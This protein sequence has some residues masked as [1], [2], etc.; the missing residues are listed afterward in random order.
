MLLAD[1]ERQLSEKEKLLAKAMSSY[2]RYDMGQLEQEV[3]A[4]MA[5]EMQQFKQAKESKLQAIEQ[6][7]DE[8]NSLS[9]V[10]VAKGSQYKS[11]KK[12]GKS[13]GSEEDGQEVMHAFEEQ[14]KEYERVISTANLQKQALRKD[15]LKLEQ[16]IR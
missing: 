6:L 7:L 4:L 12:K 2:F 15:I 16:G 8:I 3:I 13:A 10:H 11:Q 1:K 9:K 5:E 14:S